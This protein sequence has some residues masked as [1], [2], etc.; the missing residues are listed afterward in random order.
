MHVTSV[1]GDPSLDTES[2]TSRMSRSGPGTAR[3]GRSGDVQI[4]PERLADDVASGRVVE[5]RALFNGHS[6]CGVEA[7]WN[8]LG[9]G[10]THESAP[11]ASTKCRGLVA[12]LSFGCEAFDLGIVTEVTT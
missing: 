1:E 4:V 5:L 12:D 9:R 2:T 8:D 7:D 3:P 11:T 10:G 6:E